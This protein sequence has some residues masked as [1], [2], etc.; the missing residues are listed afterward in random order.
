MSVIGGAKAIDRMGGIPGM[1][2]MRQEV[3]RGD[4]AGEGELKGAKGLRTMDNMSI[5]GEVVVSPRRFEGMLEEERKR[6]SWAK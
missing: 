6:N 2:S 1:I 5:G 4:R 3:V